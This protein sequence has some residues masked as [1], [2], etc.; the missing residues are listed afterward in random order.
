MGGSTLEGYLH[1]THK[2]SLKVKQWAIS[3]VCNA[4]DWSVSQLILLRENSPPPYNATC[5]QITLDSVVVKKT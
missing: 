1:D 2:D 4:P 3:S 5:S